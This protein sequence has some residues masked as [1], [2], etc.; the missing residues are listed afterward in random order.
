MPGE[1][2]SEVLGKQYERMLVRQAETIRDW[3]TGRERIEQAQIHVRTALLDQ[4]RRQITQS[5]LSRVYSILS[6]VMPDETA[7]DREATPLADLER[8]A[9]WETAYHEQLDRQSCPECGDGI[10]PGEGTGPIVPGP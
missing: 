6:Y 5:T 10:C 8:E 2:L 4:L 7:F 3:P 9:A 1:L